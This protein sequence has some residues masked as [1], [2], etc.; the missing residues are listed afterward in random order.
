[1]HLV[2]LLG[3]NK[4]FKKLKN[5]LSSFGTWIKKKGVVNVIWLHGK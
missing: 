4:I 1:L 5:L 2:A 3:V